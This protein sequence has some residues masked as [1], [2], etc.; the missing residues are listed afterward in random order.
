MVHVKDEGTFGP[1]HRLR[2]QIIVDNVGLAPNIF[3]H[4]TQEGMSEIS[5]EAASIEVG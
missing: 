1:W 3:K 2:V 4:Q 5:S